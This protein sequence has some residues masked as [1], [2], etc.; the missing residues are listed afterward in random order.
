MTMQALEPERAAT[1]DSGGYRGLRPALAAACVCA[2]IGLTGCV[3][4]TIQQVRQG[5]TGVDADDRVVVL[6]RR[7][8]RGYETETDFVSC[9]GDK[10]SDGSNGVTVLSEQE[11]VDTLYPWFEPR[12]APSSPGDLPE[13]LNQEVVAQQ[14]EEQGIRYL[15]WVDGST[16]TTGTTGSMTCSISPG[17]GGCFGFLSWQQDSSYEASVWDLRH[18]KSVGKL[19]SDATGTSYMPA[20]VIPLPLIARVQASACKGLGNQLRTFLTAQG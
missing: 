11:F 19:S 17:G 8:N 18:G 1:P 14:L 6:G 20:V 4:S 9:L 2:A 10:L 7:A 3:S 5:A 13:L 15:I 16:D 12:T